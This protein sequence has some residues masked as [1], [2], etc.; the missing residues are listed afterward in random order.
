MNRL[1]HLRHTPRTS[2]TVLFAGTLAS[3]LLTVVVFSSEIHWSGLFSGW[4]MGFNHALNKPWGDNAGVNLA[5]TV[6][7]ALMTTVL[8]L[9]L[10]LLS[11]SILFARVLRKVAGPV[12]VAV[13]PACLWMVYRYRLDWLDPGWS[14]LIPEGIVAVVCAVLFAW[15]RWPFSQRVSTALLVFH[16]TLWWRYYSS[17]FEVRAFCWTIPPIVSGL[18]TLGW[19]SL[20]RDRD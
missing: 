5:F 9:L 16:M 19:G 2:S 20:P 15:N 8:A 13:P 6:C 14:W 12:G 1:P 11:R 3:G 10:F 4:R 7:V 18:S 17:A